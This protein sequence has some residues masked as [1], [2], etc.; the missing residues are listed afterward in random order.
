[1]VKAEAAHLVVAQRHDEILQALTTAV[2]ELGLELP[3]AASMT[4]WFVAAERLA[5]AAT[6]AVEAE[7]QFEP[8]ADRVAK[9]T[10]HSQRCRH[11]LD[12]LLT[13]RGVTASPPDDSFV[14]WLG[15][16][17]QASRDADDLR[18]AQVELAERR[19]EFDRV[20]QPVAAEVASWSWDS[21]NMQLER[22]EDDA[23]HRDALLVE[24]SRAEAAAGGARAN[25]PKIAEL[26]VRHRSDEALM[27][28]LR[29][30]EE[31]IATADR[32]RVELVERRTQLRFEIDQ[33]EGHE[34]LPGLQLRR[35]G[36]ESQRDE[37]EREEQAVSIAAGILGEVIDKYE[38]D[39]QDPLVKR[40]QQRI[41]S[42]VDGWGTLLYSRAADGKVVIE[43]DGDGGRLDDAR[44]SDGGRAL[45]YL[46]IRLACIERDAERR[47]IRL[48]V[49]C[50]DALIHFD[51]ERTRAGLRLL[52]DTSLR[53]QVVLF[54][55][56]RSTRDLAVAHGAVAIEM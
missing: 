21:I 48:P 23:R 16:Y 27:V 14:E 42:V 50:D 31:Q 9:A 8:A 30:V 3:D 40:A 53:H 34:V 37:L 56:E 32:H 44:L 47:G 55:C 25:D 12:R 11:E 43:R 38:R 10:E 17:E 36:L 41:A 28:L 1:L 4:T 39:H 7:L 20:L 29:Q 24:L 52:S 51:D 46:G 2:G 5:V 49:I 26:L 15:A 18:T 13:A 22:H 19:S 35:S 6:A 54:T 33:L 45:L